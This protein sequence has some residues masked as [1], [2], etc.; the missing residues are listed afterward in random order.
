M[1]ALYS[2]AVDFLLV[3]QQPARAERIDVVAVAEFVGVDVGVIQPALA[4]FDPR[5]SIVDR[6]AGVAERLDLRAPQLDAR[7]VCLGDEIVAAGFV[8]L[9]RR[10]HRRPVYWPRA[11]NPNSKNV[12]RAD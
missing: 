7:F 12:T 6:R 5:K 4:A 9:D 3:Q 8:V 2:Q 11:S 10:D 1:W